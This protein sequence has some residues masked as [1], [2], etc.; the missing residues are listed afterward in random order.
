MRSRSEA[1]RG[2]KEPLLPADA[3]GIESG[4]PLGGL[5]AGGGDS[6]GAC[7]SFGGGAVGSSGA[8]QGSGGTSLEATWSPEDSD[9]PLVPSKIAHARPSPTT[10]STPATHLLKRSLPTAPP[11]LRRV[12]AARSF[13]W[14][15]PGI[16]SHNL[17]RS[18]REDP[19]RLDRPAFVAKIVVLVRGTI[20]NPPRPQQGTARRPGP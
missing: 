20:G 19:A 14:P 2:L 13:T 17:E 1:G 8:S 18:R 7:S 3:G 16:A 10:A 4:P 6:T 15:P 5:T 11:S 9:G 12:S